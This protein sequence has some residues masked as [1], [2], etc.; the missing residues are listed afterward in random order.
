[1]L[2]SPPCWVNNET[3]RSCL[4]V[5]EA[6]RRGPVSSFGLWRKTETLR[7]RAGVENPSRIRSV[8]RADEVREQ[9]DVPIGET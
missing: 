7:G 2:N 6:G 5:K 1:M 8:P 3:R 9:A 4:G